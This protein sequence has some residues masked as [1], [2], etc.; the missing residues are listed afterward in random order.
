MQLVQIFKAIS[1]SVARNVCMSVPDST[2]LFDQDLN[3]NKLTHV[4]FID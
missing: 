1:A 3:K 2:R 4:H